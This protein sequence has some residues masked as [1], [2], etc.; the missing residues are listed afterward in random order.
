[1]LMLMPE[2]GGG[3]GAGVGDGEAGFLVQDWGPGHGRG[4]E[5]RGLGG[6]GVYNRFML[7]CQHAGWRIASCS[8][9]E[10]RSRFWPQSTLSIFYRQAPHRTLFAAQ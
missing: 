1:M 6:G 5:E 10:T 3:R 4:Q 8:R 7:S 9:L 2:G